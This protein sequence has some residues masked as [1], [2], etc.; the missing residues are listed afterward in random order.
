MNQQEKQLTDESENKS[1][2]ERGRSSFIF[3]RPLS[4]FTPLDCPVSRRPSLALS[5]PPVSLARLP[6][7]QADRRGGFLGVGAGALRIMIGELSGSFWPEFFLDIWN[8]RFSISPV[9][10]KILGWKWF[11]GHSIHWQVGIVLAIPRALLVWCLGF[12]GTRR[13]GRSLDVHGTPIIA[14]LQPNVRVI[15]KR[16]WPQSLA[17]LTAR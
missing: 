7:D 16:P 5:D 12:S 10:F 2:N 1:E 3:G 8:M 9:I 11:Y 4:G 17:F 6:R 13:R 14:N 15:P